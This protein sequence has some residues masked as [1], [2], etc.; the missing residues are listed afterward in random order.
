MT[1]RGTLQLAGG[2]APTANQTDAEALVASNAGAN[3]QTKTAGSVGGWTLSSS[4]I[5]STNITLDNTNVRI[6]IED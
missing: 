5:S 4:T 6:L 3:S 2:T 1:I